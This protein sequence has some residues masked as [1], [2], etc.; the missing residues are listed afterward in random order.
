MRDSG[1][2]ELTFTLCGFPEESSVHSDST[3]EAD[4]NTDVVPGSLKQPNLTLELFPNHSENLE[5]AKK[6]KFAL[7][8]LPDL[9]ADSCDYDFHFF[10]L[11]FALTYCVLC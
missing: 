8:E 9:Y 3:V 2:T 11:V 6:V 7:C 10:Y 5:T 1:L 4:N